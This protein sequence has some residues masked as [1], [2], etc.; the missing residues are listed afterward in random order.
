M[1][2]GPGRL[3]SLLGVTRVSYAAG[4]HSLALVDSALA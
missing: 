3:R 4:K 1:A 2:V